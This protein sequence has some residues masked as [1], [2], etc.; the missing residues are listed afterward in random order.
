MTMEEDM[1]NDWK[2]TN[3]VEV[4][5][6]T[7]KFGPDADY[8]QDAE[9]SL[10]WEALLDVRNWG[11]KDLSFMLHTNQIQFEIEVESPT[12][13]N[14][15]D[16]RTETVTVPLDPEKVKVEYQNGHGMYPSQI[17]VHDFKGNL[18]VIIYV[19]MPSGGRND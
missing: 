8:E 1:A 17:Q 16:K 11:I 19:T 6:Y 9:V 2:F 18:E 12:T 14:N 5:Y 10:N 15:F 13:N 4:E 3:R 7:D